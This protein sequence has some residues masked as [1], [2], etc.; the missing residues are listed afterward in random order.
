MTEVPMT[1][2]NQ[3]SRSNFP[4]KW[5]K[6]QR[7]DHISEAI[8]STDFILGTNVQLNKVHLLIIVKVILTSALGLLNVNGL[9]GYTLV[10]SMKSVGEIASEI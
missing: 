4:K 3:R 8:S 9:L 6:N 5:V 10:P 7:T 1:L 2:T